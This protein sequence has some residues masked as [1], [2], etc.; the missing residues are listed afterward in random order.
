MV[1]GSPKGS[2]FYSIIVRLWG[3]AVAEHIDHP[4]EPIDEEED[5]KILE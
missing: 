4:V 1:F 5:A 2:V 3:Y